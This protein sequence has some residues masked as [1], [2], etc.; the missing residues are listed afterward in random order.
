MPRLRKREP[1]SFISSHLNTKRRLTGVGDG[2]AVGRLDVVHVRHQVERGLR[3]V[4]AGVVQEDGQAEG[5]VLLIG[6]PDEQAA[7]AQR[8]ETLSAHGRQRMT[9]VRAAKRIK[10]RHSGAAIL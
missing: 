4:G 3:G 5:G 7:C 9:N 10:P 2:E 6:V 1:K 8:G